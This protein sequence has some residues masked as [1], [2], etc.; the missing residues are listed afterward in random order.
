MENRPFLLFSLRGPMAAFGEIAVGQRR[1]LWDAPSK[2]GVFGF[3]AACL[4]IKREENK[5]LVALEE[6]FGFAVRVENYGKALRDF[7]TAQAPTEAAR[8]R[9]VKIGLPLNTRKDDLD[10]DDLTTM[11][12]DRYYR[13]EAKYTIAIWQKTEGEFGLLSVIDAIMSPVFIPYLGRKSCPIGFPPNPIL[14][15]GENLNEAF[16]NYDSKCFEQDCLLTKEV[17]FLRNQTFENQDIWFEIDRNLNV[18]NQDYQIRERRDSIRNR[19]LWQFSNRQE[20]KIQFSPK[21][22]GVIE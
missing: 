4:G 11:L 1:S 17:K 19:S 18:G 20:G 2:S 15:E 12:S 14:I 6:T 5:R 10:C 8:S 3:I 21:I 7:H 16:Q 13:L 9:R 22:E